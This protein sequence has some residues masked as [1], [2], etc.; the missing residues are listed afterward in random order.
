M[1]NKKKLSYERKR[2]LIYVMRYS[3]LPL[4]I[5]AIIWLALLVAELLDK[6]NSFL[7]NT[8][9][10]IWV[11][12]IIDFV[13]K[14]IIATSKLQFLKKNILTLISLVIPAFRILRFIRIFR[15]VRL[16]RSLRLVKLLGSFNRGMRSLANTLERRAVI[17]VVI[18]SGIVVLLGA[19]GMYAFE[20]EVNQGFKSFS[21]SLWWT[22]ML[23]MSMGTEN[24]PKTNEGRFLT[25][26][27]AIY[28]LAVFGYITATIA[29]FFIGKDKEDNS[30][31]DNVKQM[32]DLRKEILSLKEE[33][34][35]LRKNNQTTDGNIR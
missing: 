18:L 9:I 10:V 2:L 16:T 20:K 21:S 3:E 19:A 26:L 24:W 13:L 31:V 1:D 30:K 27:I 4:F 17:Y 34:V 6:S 8:G 11:I 23:V 28:G 25:I 14:F 29:T 22:A 5:L 15:L 33:I 12:F 32:E 35:M 7:T